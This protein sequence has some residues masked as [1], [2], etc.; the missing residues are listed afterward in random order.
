LQ[1]FILAFFGWFVL[2]GKNGIRIGDRVEINGVGGEVTEIGLMSTTL[3]ETGNLANI[4]LPTGRRISFINSFAVRG[5][6]FNFSTSGQWMWDEITVSVPATTDPLAMVERIHKVVQEETQEDASIAVQEWKRG[7][8]SDNLSR[9]STAPEVN[10]RPS[11]T[12]FDIQVRYVTRA[13]A[14]FE[15]RTALYK[16]AFELLQEQNRPAQAEQKPGAVVAS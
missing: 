8:H 10:L 3:I 6:Y 2:M 13:S 7:A 5:Q 1:D 14:R 11:A 4:G 12:G 9:F 16:R 15:M